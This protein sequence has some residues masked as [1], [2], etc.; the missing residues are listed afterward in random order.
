MARGA[1]WGPQAN[2]NY[3]EGNPVADF[4]AEK[5]GKRLEQLNREQL[6][7]LEHRADRLL[8]ELETARAGP[9]RADGTAGDE[10]PVTVAPRHTGKRSHAK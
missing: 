4:D 9:K 10:T 3:N 1:P 6:A 5:L 2:D 8:R 7:A